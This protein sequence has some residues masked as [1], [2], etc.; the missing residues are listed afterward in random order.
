MYNVLLY[1]SKMQKELYIYYIY[2]FRSNEQLNIALV[3][4]LLY[5]MHAQGT[6]MAC[7]WME[8]GLAGTEGDSWSPMLIPRVPSSKQYFE[9]CNVL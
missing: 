9:I 5:C 3:L 2:N 8:E 7:H 1:T 4:V 6:P